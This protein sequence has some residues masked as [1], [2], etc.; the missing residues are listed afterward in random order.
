MRP[1]KISPAEMAGQENAGVSAVVDRAA[2]AVEDADAGKT[3]PSAE[4]AATDE[5]RSADP[6]EQA[7]IAKLNETSN[8]KPVSAAKPA[9]EKTAPK[10]SPETK[11]ISKRAVEIRQK[12]RTVA[13]VTVTRV[14]ARLKAAK[15]DAEA[16]VKSFKTIKNAHEYAGGDKSI[17]TPELVKQVNEKIEDPFAKSRG[18]VAICLALTDR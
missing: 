4:V 10:Y 14:E 8:G 11:A 18:L 12:E 13:P 5:A 6:K 9:R 7:R 15:T 2:Q 17:D 16:V 3:P 1:I